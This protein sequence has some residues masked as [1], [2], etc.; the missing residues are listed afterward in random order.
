MKQLGSIIGI[1]LLILACKRDFNAEAGNVSKSLPMSETELENRLGKP[2][3][4][5]A[6]T[7]SPVVVYL[8]DRSGWQWTFWVHGGAVRNGIGVKGKYIDIPSVRKI[9]GDAPQLDSNVIQKMCDDARLH[10]LL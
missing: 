6:A 5:I 9:I 4:K 3:E 1:T 2:E 7:K 8:Y 10:G